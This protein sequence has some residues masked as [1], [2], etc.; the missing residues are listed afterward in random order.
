MIKIA[1]IL[2]V[3]SSCMSQVPGVPVAETQYAG[4]FEAVVFAWEQDPSLPTIE[5]HCNDF[6]VAVI[7]REDLHM[8]SGPNADGLWGF[9]SGNVAVV[10]DD[11]RSAESLRGTVIHESTH[12]LTLCTGLDT[13][14]LAHE[15]ARLWGKDGVEVRVLNGASHED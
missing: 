12:W 8:Y 4:T 6:K 14:D 15:D 11:N 5:D 3:V 10:I 13:D 2:A 1:I 7:A 9:L